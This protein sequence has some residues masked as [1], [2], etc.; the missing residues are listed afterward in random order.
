MNRF[1]VRVR[2]YDIER[3][4]LGLLQIPSSLAVSTRRKIGNIKRTRVLY[5]V[6]CLDIDKRVRVRGSTS[7]NANHAASCHV[8]SMASGINIYSQLLMSLIRIVDISNSNY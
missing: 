4:L 7:A 2:L 6:D 8:S 3:H 5:R 1:R